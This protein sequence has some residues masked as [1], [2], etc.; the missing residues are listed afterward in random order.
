MFGP[1]P[2]TS[3]RPECIATAGGRPIPE[4]VVESTA[5]LIVGRPP[6]TLC[7]ASLCR[8]RRYHLIGEQRSSHVRLSFATIPEGR[9]RP[10][11]SR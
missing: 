7:G 10:R 2:S 1:A 9:L 8:S 5:S 4:P 11:F 6:R 3:I